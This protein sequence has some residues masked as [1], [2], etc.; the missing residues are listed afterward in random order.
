MLCI[1]P[2]LKSPSSIHY[3]FQF[4]LLI[5]LE[6]FHLL[7]FVQFLFLPYDLCLSDGS[8]ESLWRKPSLKASTLLSTLLKC[9]A[10]FLNKTQMKWKTKMSFS[11]FPL[12]VY[13]WGRE[14]REL[15]PKYSKNSKFPNSQSCLISFL[16]ACLRTLLAY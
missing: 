11:N 14:I 13:V 7:S 12:E 3:N 15:F 1:V 4:L 9:E 2:I 5:F 8:L 16:Q 10:A 6:N